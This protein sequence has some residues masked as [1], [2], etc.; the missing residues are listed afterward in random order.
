MMKKFASRFS[1]GPFQKIV[2]RG[3]K[4]GW[5]PFFEALQ[6]HHFNFF[7]LRLKIVLG[8][9]PRIEKTAAGPEN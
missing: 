3:R 5:T 6:A 1:K 7:G 8:A 2:F 4:K 9:H